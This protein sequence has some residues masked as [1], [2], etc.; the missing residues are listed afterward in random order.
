MGGGGFRV[1]LTS[2]LQTAV[3]IGPAVVCAVF[4]L[5]RRGYMRA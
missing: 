3:A 1:L 2:S 4:E 5:F